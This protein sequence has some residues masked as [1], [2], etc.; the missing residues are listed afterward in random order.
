MSY[1]LVHEPFVTVSLRD[2]GGV[3]DLGVLEVL[4]R[5]HEIGDLVVESPTQ[6]PALLRQVLLPVV[7]AAL[8]LPADQ[9][10]W[11]RRFSARRF[12]RQENEEI[13]G[14]LERYRER[15]DLFHPRTP[16]AQVGGLRSPKDETKGS[17][18]IVATAATG[19][20]VPLFAS[21]S[22]ADPLPLTPA[23]AARWLV[24][25]QC[26]DTASIKTGAA[27]D[28][29]VKSGKT[30]GNP[31]GP[32]GQLGVVMPVGETL[33]DTLILNLPIG[34]AG[35]VGT[36]QWEREPAGPAWQTRAPDG[37]VDLWTWQSRR[38]RLIPEDTADGARVTRVIV[39][40]GDRLT[41]YEDLEWH[42][43]WTFPKA[44]KGR[45]GV[46]RR[47]RRHLPGKAIWR[48]LDALLT[49]EDIEGDKRSFQTSRLLDQLTGLQMDGA[50]PEAYPLRLETFGIVYGTQSA[51]VEDVVHDA[52]PLPVAA[53]RNHGDA[54]A[55]LVE[56][57]EQA[58]NLARAVNN[59]SADL[60]R[61]VGADPIPWDKG[62]RPGELV[63]HSVDP[64]V[65]RLLAGV[66]GAGSDSDFLA[67][68]QL[69]WE[70][71]AYRKTWQVAETLLAAVPAA[72][73]TGREINADGKTTT[74]RLATAEYNFRRRLNQILSR[75][76][77]ARTDRKS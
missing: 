52:M 5:A 44:G 10:D 33:Y 55:L 1:D 2:G 48:G 22:E 50:I 65:R 7:V 49:V 45:T 19:N 41:A 24:H 4:L 18:L 31:T 46:E 12:S 27:G 57:S 71:L 51:V 42:T 72:A 60:R 26:W 32:L 13:E 3:A 43:A 63:L 30:T 75:A 54:Y 59:L 66:S 58:E 6:R 39:A 16:F 40:A 29:K 23:Q 25:L 76:A 70:E 74:Y 21:R 67:R 64:L 35:Q 68:G 8:G 17:A 36:P 73:F 34:S 14:Y 47:P 56:V 15:F 9:R 20:N 38:A 53:L 28:S 69:A 11:A 61:A 77:Q 62:Q 37:L